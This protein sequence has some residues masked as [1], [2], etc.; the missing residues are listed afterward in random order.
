MTR[1][2]KQYPAVV[3]S[4]PNI[5]AASVTETTGSTMV[6][7]AARPVSTTFKPLLYSQ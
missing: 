2:A 6:M 4:S 1:A 7:I 5:K 3:K